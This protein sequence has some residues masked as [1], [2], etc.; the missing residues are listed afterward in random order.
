LLAK[1]N[2]AQETYNKKLLAKF[3]LYYILKRTNNNNQFLRHFIVANMY[4]W[5]VFAA[6]NFYEQI[7]SPEIEKLNG[8]I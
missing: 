7:S 6:K 3:L 2:V 4:E 8:F 1:T 5:F